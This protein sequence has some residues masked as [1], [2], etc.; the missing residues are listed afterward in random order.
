M[1]DLNALARECMDELD[2]I[3]IPY[4]KNV[5]FI[6]NTRAKSRWG[7]CSH[8]PD[9]TYRIQ[10]SSRLLENGIAPDGA[11]NTI[12]HELLHTCPGGHGH[13][14][15]WKRYAQIVNNAYGYN[16]QR[17]SSSEEKGVAEN[18]DV[19]AKYILACSDCGRKWRFNRLTNSLK[20]YT[21]WF[22]PD[23]CGVVKLVKGRIPKQ[24][25]VKAKKTVRYKFVCQ[26]CG[27]VA[28]RSRA[29]DFTKNTYRYRCAKCK[30]FFK[31]VL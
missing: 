23:C 6:V 16:I 30:G 7:L 2:A 12:I 4:S 31:R 10:I 11:K 22:C 15:E 26:S 9:G 14:G 25:R 24:K 13:K 21:T 8:L 28:T 18:T 27:A 19:D 29:C 1:Q 17:T 20:N 3:H 5:F